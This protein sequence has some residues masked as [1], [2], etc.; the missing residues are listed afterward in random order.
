MPHEVKRT[1]VTYLDSPPFYQSTKDTV[2]IGFSGKKGSGK[3]TCAD[4][5]QGLITHYLNSIEE[6]AT[7]RPLVKCYAFANPL[8]ETCMQ[9]FNLTHEQCYGTDEEKNTLTTIRWADV[10]LN[11]DVHPDRCMT[12]REVLQYVGTDILR[13]MNPD[14]H[15]N[16]LMHQIHKENPL[17]AII[18]D[19]RFPNEVRSITEHH[20]V[21]R[22][23][24]THHSTGRVIRLKRAPFTTDQHSS[25]K[26]LDKPWYSWDNFDL[27]IDNDTMDLS[28]QKEMI[29]EYFEYMK[30][31]KMI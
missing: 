11:L 29:K 26:A 3:N 31:T 20:E 23:T 5:L 24:G 8:K 28:Q 30:L 2:I 12:A 7:N 19:V 4:T 14:A 9:F 21:G 13:K 6:C 17:Y 15:V 25:E 16:A 27:V 1:T 22:T 18:T 10:P